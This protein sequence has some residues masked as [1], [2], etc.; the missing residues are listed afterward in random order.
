M[1]GSQGAAATVRLSR[2]SSLSA[3]AEEYKIILPP[4]PTGYLAKNA[5]F[6]HCDMRYRPYR[7]QDFKEELEGPNIL[8]ELASAGAHQMNRARMLRLH[9]LSG[10]QRL[11]DT[12]ELR[13]KGG[14]CLVFDPANTEVKVKLHWVPYD[15]PNYQVRQELERFGKVTDISRDNFREKRFENVESNTGLVQV[16]LNEGTTVE[17]PHGLRIKGCKVLVIV[18][19]RAPLCLRCR[20]IGHIRR[21]CRVPGCNECDRYGHDSESCAKTYAFIARE[22][23]HEDVDDLIMDEVEAED[24]AASDLPEGQPGDE[25]RKPATTRPSDEAAT[26]SECAKE[27][28]NVVREADET[29]P[30]PPTVRPQPLEKVAKATDDGFVHHPLQE[31]DEVTDQVNMIDASVQLKKRTLEKVSPT[32]PVDDTIGETQ[33]GHGKGTKKI[34]KTTKPGT[35]EGVVRRHKDLK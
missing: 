6:L 26:S 12:K 20:L 15:V 11:V 25:P 23:R 31:G 17:I 19:G 2:G 33:Q 24:T 5:V 9:S 7:I 29:S 21:N 3:T 34:R 16:T 30:P 10:K 32:A 1:S 4:L 8:Q 14:R 27:P 18:P 22:R 35:A 13:N 28:T